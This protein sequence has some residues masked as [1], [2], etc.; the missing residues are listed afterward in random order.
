[1]EHGLK[2]I[3]SYVKKHIE[4]RAICYNPLFRDKP[5]G[6]PTVVWWIYYDTSTFIQE[7]EFENDAAK[8]TAQP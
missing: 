4:P 6:A 2:D 7:K 1:M 5:L 8:C 3:K